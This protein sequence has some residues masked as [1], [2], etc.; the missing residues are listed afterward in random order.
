MPTT[1]N[2]LAGTISD[3]PPGDFRYILSTAESKFD[4]GAAIYKLIQAVG[5]LSANLTGDHPKYGMKDFLELVPED[6]RVEII[7]Y[8]TSD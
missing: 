5:M 6:L 7:G 1:P 4:T 3:N 2:P 8:K